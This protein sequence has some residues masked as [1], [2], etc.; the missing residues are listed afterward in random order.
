RDR[1][2]FFFFSLLHPRPPRSPLFPYTTLFRSH[3]GGGRRQV[4]SAR[5]RAPSVVSPASAP[6]ELSGG[7]RNGD[8]NR[9]RKGTC[10][11]IPGIRVRHT[12]GRSLRTRSRRVAVRGPSRPARGTTRRPD[13]PA[14]ETRADS[15][16]AAHG[17]DLRRSHPRPRRR[18][19][20]RCPQDPAGG[21]GARPARPPGL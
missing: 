13:N 6:T 9:V 3:G 18:R 8:P 7:R 11:Q 19:A 14:S 12:S 20:R 21:D 4:R 2:T 5:R 15:T 17:P 10:G 16:G 1:I